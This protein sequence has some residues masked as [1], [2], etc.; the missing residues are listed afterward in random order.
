MVRLEGAELNALF[1]VLQEW[2]THLAHTDLKD[3]WCEDDT[4]AP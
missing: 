2:E 4:F 1:E 3:Q